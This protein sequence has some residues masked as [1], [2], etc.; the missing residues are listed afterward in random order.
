MLREIIYTER[1]KNEI[2]ENIDIN[3]IFKSWSFKYGP[4]KKFVLLCYEEPNEFC[5]RHIVAE[6]IEN[7]YS[8]KILEI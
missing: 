2:L 5:H 1:F 6:A 8:I 3:E 7:K 4:L